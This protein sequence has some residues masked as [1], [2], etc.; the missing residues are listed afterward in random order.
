[1][2]LLHLLTAAALTLGTG[3]CSLLL[4]APVEQCKRTSDCTARG[5]AFAQSICGAQGVCV[6]LASEDCPTVLGTVDD[7]AVLIGVMT[8][9][10]SDNG[11]TGKARVQSAELALDELVS[12]SVG[13]PRGGGRKPRSLVA[14]ECDQDVDMIRAADHLFNKLRI[15]ALIGP[16]H[17]GDTLTLATQVTIP[18]GVLMINPSAASTTISTLDD[19]GLVWR[20]SSSDKIEAYAVSL[21]MPELEADIRATQG[22]SAADKIRVA[23]LSKTDAYGKGLSD[24]MFPLLM[25]NGAS[26]KDN[27]DYF[28]SRELPDSSKDPDFDPTQVVADVVAHRPSV[29]FLFGTAEM[30]NKGMANIEA[31]WPSGA[32]APPRPRYVLTEGAKNADLFKLIGT[33]NDDL[34][35]RVVGFEPRP[36]TDLYGA[37]RLRYETK[38]GPSPDV[39]GMAGTYDAM[40]LLFYALVALGDEPITGASVA[41]MLKRTVPPGARVDAGPG[42]F[43][44][45]FDLLMKGESIDYNGVAGPLDFDLTV[46]EAPADYDL[47]CVRRTTDGSTE[48][49]SSGRHFDTTQNALTGTFSCP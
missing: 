41:S 37:F 25:F 5:G 21:L 48:F 22:L 11:G 30:I 46:G 19:N 10:S 40:Y 16:A 47:W 8:S 43:P 4:D 7:D 36:N 13:L 20:T 12:Y 9:L 38:F 31:T 32:T 42:G 27:S 44:T 35:K 26:V 39:Y 24:S 1:M 28:L 33:T 6:P 29:V 3:A 49:T 18:S 34:R 17:T 15:Q 2:R 23:V 45:A 14:I